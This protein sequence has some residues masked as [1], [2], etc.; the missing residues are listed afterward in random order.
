MKYD[1]NVKS[2]ELVNITTSNFFGFDK[3]LYLNNYDQMKCSKLL[4]VQEIRSNI[5]V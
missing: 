1:S 5:S 4:Q 2:C 3:W